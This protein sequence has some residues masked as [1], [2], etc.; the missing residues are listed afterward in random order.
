MTLSPFLHGFAR[1]A[2]RADE[3]VNIVR[4]EGAR[5]FD[6]QG[7]S[8][9]EGMGSLWYCQIGYGRTEMGEAIG[10]Q[11]G[12]LGGSH[13]FDMFTN[14]PAEAVCAE[15]AALAPMPDARVFLASGGSE[16]VDSAIKIARQAHTQ[17]GR[18]E[19]TVILARTPSYH[20]MTY[21]GLA[22]TGIMAHKPGFGAMLPDVAHAPQDDL[23][24]IGA[25]CAQH[26]GKIA[27]IIA[28]PVIGAPGVYPPKPGY[29]AGLRALAD[30]HGAYLIMDEVICGF[31]RL[32]SWFGS[33]HYGISPD[34]VTFA[35]GVTSGYVQLGGVLMGKAVR[36]PLEADAGFLFRHGY[37]YGG[38]PVACAAGVTNLEIM[39]R[40]GLVERAKP[41]GA[42]LSAGLQAV[43]AAY[44]DKV[45]EV[46]GEGAVWAVGLHDGLD[47][48]KV[49]KEMLAHGAICRPIAPSTLAFC[50]PLVIED[51]DIDVLLTALDAG[52]GAL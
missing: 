16:A 37:T 45:K 27:A 35:K 18:P 3:F 5:V 33:Q 47:P 4:G 20:G 46:R 49:R 2:A 51:A 24:A 25:L 39:K 15:L 11:A 8:Y 9:V 12:L 44:G 28:E 42:R 29:L 38:H 22:A 31:G 26:A 48:A 41:V 23:D 13:T 40:E 43:A 17:A 32:G 21:G 52:I 6:D 50:P 34:M 14:A 30:Q 10:K 1:P 7:R 36:E 19:K